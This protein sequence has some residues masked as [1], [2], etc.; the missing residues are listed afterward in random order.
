MKTILA[1]TAHPDDE[2][3]LFGGA[4]AL[5]ARN[6]GKTALLCLTDGQ[7][8]RTGGLCTQEELA[9]VRRAELEK[10]AA[11]LEIGELHLERLMDGS[12][13]ELSDEDGAAIVAHYVEETGADV[14]LTFGPEGASGHD[15]HRACYR[16]TKAAANGRPVY[17]GAWPAGI[18][19]PHGETSMQ[20]TTVVDIAA[21]G[22]L[23]RRA[24]LEHKTQIDHLER[25]DEIMGKFDSK[26]YY[27]RV[28][29]PWPAGAPLETSVV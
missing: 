29:P 25:F 7:I 16:W 24:F 21:L 20:P 14:L 15:D 3:F 13:S 23:K 9:A 11:L 28:S 2:S 19:L 5:H 22:D 17:V 4:M 1:V 6:G 12:L 26:E 8:G 27:H 10:A 18:E